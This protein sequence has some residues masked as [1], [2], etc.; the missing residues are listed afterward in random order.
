MTKK[1]TLLLLPNLLGPVE[2]QDLYLPSSVGRAVEGLDG[3]ISESD[4]GGKKFLSYFKR[5]LPQILFNKNTPDGDIDF[6]LEP[7]VKGER[8]GYVSDAGLPCIA[9]PGSKLVKRARELGCGVQA[10]SG[11]SS[12]TLALMLSGLESQ[13]F[14]FHGYFSDRTTI[15]DLQRMGRMCHLFIEAPHKNDLLL[16]KLIAEAPQDAELSTAVNLTLPDQAV[17]TQKVATWRKVPRPIL[18]GKTVLFILKL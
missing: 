17:I 8:W 1:G 14:C 12:I 9:D 13:A 15:A 4:K 11:P 10:F 7:I 18:K 3:L 6:I 5:M 2:H 16:A